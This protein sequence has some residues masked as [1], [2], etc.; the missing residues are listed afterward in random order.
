MIGHLF[1]NYNAVKSIVMRTFNRNRYHLL[2]DSYF[3]TDSILRPAV[4]NRS[5][6]VLKNVSRYFGHIDLGC[7]V[8]DLFFTSLSDCSK[9]KRFEDEKYLIE[10]N[11][12]S[13]NKNFL[14]NLLEFFKI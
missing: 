8:K 14:I 4:V 13:N 10:F 12:K 2:L 7:S 1:A 3:R 5:E 9:L 11:V 6:P